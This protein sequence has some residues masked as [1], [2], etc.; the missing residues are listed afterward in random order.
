MAQI[1][2]DDVYLKGGATI[3]VVGSDGAITTLI[4]AN[5]VPT[6]TGAASVT[7]LAASGA[8]TFSSTTALNGT[9]TLGTNNKVQFRD[10][11]IYINSANDGYMDV[12]ADTAI[13]V[14]TPSTIIS[15]ANANGLVVGAN[16]ATN[17]VLKVNTATASVATGISITGA[18]AAGGVAVAAIS[19]GTDEA[20]T[21]NAKG[22]GAIGIGSVSTGAVT[23]T[24]ATTIT[25]ALTCTAGVQATAYAA[26]ATATGATTGTIPAG[27]SF[28]TVTSTDAGHLVKL[29]APVLGNQ[30]FIKE[31]STVGFNVIPAATTQYINGTLVDGSKKL[32]AADGVGTL[33]FI[34]TV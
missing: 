30:I 2:E 25:G 34:C 27:T 16:G 22:A 24:P 11:A 10:T 19:S 12:A 29:P 18:A 33:H 32:A 14:A 6:P 9:T 15:G 5:G 1:F 7:T 26:T 20:L 17:P 4:D 13:R 3:G 21:I 28:V 8:V 23:I 31:S